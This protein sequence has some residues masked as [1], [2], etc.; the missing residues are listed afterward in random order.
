MRVNKTA[1]LGTVRQELV[2]FDRETRALAYEVRAGLPP[3]LT[4]MRNNS[5]IDE[6]GPDRC[7]LDGDAKF[8]LSEAAM[9]MRPKLEGR[10]GM[11]LAAFAKAARTRLEGTDND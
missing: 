4:S 1:S 2:R 11:V 3:F 9:A 7:R 8:V 6:I 10:M 5:V